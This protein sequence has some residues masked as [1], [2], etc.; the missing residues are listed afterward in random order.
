MGNESFAKG[1]VSLCEC[2]WLC[3]RMGKGQKHMYIRKAKPTLAVME[4]GHFF[5]SAITPENPRLTSLMSHF[6]KQKFSLYDRGTLID[7]N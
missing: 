2:G 6:S 4:Y 1:H 7:A 5:Q 3:G